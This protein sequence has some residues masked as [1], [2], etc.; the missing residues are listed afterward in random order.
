MKNEIS[1]YYEIKKQREEISAPVDVM[2][3]AS[4]PVE[5]DDE[6]RKLYTLV[7]LFL[8][9]QTKDEITY[10]A[11]RNLIKSLPEESA[12]KTGNIKKTKNYNG[13]T[14]ENLVNSSEQ[15]ID[16]C[17][18]KVG[19]HKTKAKNLKKIADILKK[20][21]LPTT[22][23]EAIELPGIGEKMGF[24]YMLHG[25]NKVLGIG[26][27]THVHRIVNR[28]GLVKTK[29]PEE[30]RREL[31]KIVPKEEWKDI[32]KVLVG[33]GQVICLASNPN[34]KKCCID[35]KCYSSMF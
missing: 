20:K 25:C 35:K 4:S 17:I 19:F 5:F 12:A 33:F 21:G 6:E 24:L 27:D 15:F 30:T 32:N 2:G 31:E 3:C 1:L 14:I 26:V 29:K 11:M 13:L 18:S 22:L 34:C 7:A 28:I 16:S 9:S 23:N 8:S 10:T